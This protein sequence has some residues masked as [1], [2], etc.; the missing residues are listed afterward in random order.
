MC[1]GWCISPSSHRR[2]AMFVLLN[3]TRC[4]YFSNVYLVIFKAFDF[5]IHLYEEG[6]KKL[7]KR[8]KHDQRFFL[9][10]FHCIDILCDLLK[11]CTNFR[12]NPAVKAG[13]NLCKM[14]MNFNL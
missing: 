2:I 1:L 4:Q 5:I 11:I 14:E 3:F 7:K 12:L 13:L 9:Q 6:M 8:N 10:N